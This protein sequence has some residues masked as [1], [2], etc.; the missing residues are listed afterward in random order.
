LQCVAVCCSVLQCVAVCCSV[1][2]CVAVC[3][4]VLQSVA[5]FQTQAH[6]MSLCCVAVCCSVLQCVVVCCSVLQCDAMGSCCVPVCLA[7]C[8]SVL[9]HR[10]LLQQH[11]SVQTLIGLFCQ[12]S[13]GTY[14]NLSWL[15]KTW[16]CHT[17]E[18]VMAHI[19]IHQTTCTNASR[20]IYQ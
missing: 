5:S 17:Y 14:M 18:W 10:P 19:Q 4:S 2:Q 3:C 9:L 16:P 11:G 6:I 20:H 12:K 7:M 1:L 15:M 8:C 13:H